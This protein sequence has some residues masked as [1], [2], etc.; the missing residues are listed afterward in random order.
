MA[1]AF[2]GAG[3]RASADFLGFSSRDADNRAVRTK[4]KPPRRHNRAFADLPPGY[5]PIPYEEV[6]QR[7]TA[8]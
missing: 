6:R 4:S 1:L 8:R 5:R 3:S 2:G 7:L